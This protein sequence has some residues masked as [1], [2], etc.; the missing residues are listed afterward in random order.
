MR[1]LLLIALAA[2]L[3]PRPGAAADAE[4]AR[5]PTCTG[6]YTGSAR[7]VFWCRVVAVHDPKTNRATFRV[8]TEDDIQLTGDALT[9]VPGGFEWTGPIAT[10]KRPSTD[11]AVVRAWSTLRTGQPP[12]EVDFVAGRGAPKVPEQGLLTLDLASAEPGATVAEGQAFTVHG[13]FTARLLPIPG[14]RGVGE[15]RVTVT[16]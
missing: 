14:A 15:V 2:L 5:H 8:E 4:R 16:F 13:T 11:P 9:V 10:G 6:I 3:L 12:N 7:G 1:P